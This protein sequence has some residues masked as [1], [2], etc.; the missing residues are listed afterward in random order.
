M[1]K[2]ILFTAIAA[3]GFSLEELPQSHAATI[4]FTPF[5][6]RLQT[7]GLPYNWRVTMTSSDSVEYQRH[8]GATSGVNPARPE[9]DV[10]GPMRAIG[11]R[12]N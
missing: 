8:V 10:F 2:P 1:I 5:D 4:E 11:Q 9:G 12:W 3:L 7:I 6:I